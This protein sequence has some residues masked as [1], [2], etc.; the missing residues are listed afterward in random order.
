VRLSITEGLGS[1]FVAPN[2]LTFGDDYPRIQL[3]IRNPINLTSLAE[4]QTDLMLG[5]IPSISCDVHCTQVGYLHFVPVTSQLY[6][7]RRGMPTRSNI[8]AGHQFIDSEYYS[9]I[10][11]LWTPWHD[12]TKRGKVTHFADN[13]FSYALLVRAGLGIGFLGTYT[14]C[15]PTS[16]ALDLGVHVAVPMYL[17]ALRERLNSRPVQLVFDWLQSIFGESNPWFHRELS[18]QT[19]PRSVL[20]DSA[21]EKILGEAPF[22]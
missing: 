10:T 14:L 7:Q 13:S 4:N 21:A 15:D 2:L 11:G 9:A 1:M 12:L 3:H 8:E 16:L 22:T 20:W 19:L 5:F 17:L 18:L 6:V